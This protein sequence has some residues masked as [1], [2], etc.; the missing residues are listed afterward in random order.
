[1]LTAEMIISKHDEPARLLTD[2]FTEKIRISSE[3]IITRTEQVYET[4]PM[5]KSG[6][7]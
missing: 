4:L 2:K 5:L 6:V 3:G 7:H 1:M